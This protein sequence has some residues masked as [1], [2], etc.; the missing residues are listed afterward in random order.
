MQIEIDTALGPTV[1]EVDDGFTSMPTANQTAL[2]DRARSEIEMQ[3]KPAPADTQRWRSALGQ[4]TLM[5]F[6]DEAEAAFWN[7]LDAIGS[8]VGLTDGAEYNAELKDIRGKLDAYR[9]D[10][11]LEALAYEMGGAVL[12]ALG[13]GLLSMGTGGAAVGAATAAR[14]AP[15]VGRLAKVGAVQGGVSGFGAGE[16]GIA[17]RLGSGATGAVIGGALGAAAPTV[18]N[19]G[20]RAVR[21]VGDSL[22]I[23]GAK[24]AQTFSERKMLEALQRDGMTPEEA[25]TRLQ[26][27]QA[28][29]VP[30]IVPADL[31]ENLR[32]AA[33]RSQAVPNPNRQAVVDQFAERQT[34]QAGQIADAA[35]DVAGSPRTGFD[36]IDDLDATVR[37]EAKPAYDLAYQQMLDPKPFQPFMGRKVIVDAYRRAQDLADIR[38]D[39]N[40]PPLDRLLS[41]NAIPTE[42]AHQIKQ[43]L[44][45]LIEA[46]TDALT[47]KVTSR[48]RELVGLKNQWNDAIVAQNDNYR[49]ANAT[50]ADRAR[51]RDGFAMGSKFNAIP[52]KELVRKVGKMTPAEREA[53][54]SG[55]ITKVQELASSTT[56]ATNF[57]KTIFGS[58]Q[59]RMALRLAF[60]DPKEFE[61]FEK[62]IR[63]QTDKVRTT[64]KV[65]G[66][67]STVE[68]QI[69]MQ[70]GGIDPSAL[71]D[72][73]ANA[74]TGNAMGMVRGLAQQGAARLTGMNEKSAESMSRMLFEADPARQQEMLN[75][76]LRRQI[77]DRDARSSV[78]ARPETYSG[79]IG[80][81]SGL[82]AGP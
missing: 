75:A 72:L 27:A 70:D 32:G 15:T 81:M 58:P 65:M 33:W 11:P 44:D 14:L 64:N 57:V 41:G 38:G 24:R 31:G 7:P 46:E 17:N 62:F 74:A 16:G 49:V 36:F 50:F 25:L 6:G 59:R 63:V 47:G 34:S 21:S 55:V 19:L 82:L 69:A 35:T 78:F 53:M 43:G 52:E 71:V 1:I 4:G 61:R 73:G 29:G 2:I 67:S 9:S 5:G 26:E 48:G 23:G 76:L 54:K 28:M 77:M 80:N 13:A 56:D 68:R 45:A 8:A 22:G 37:A 66:N 60:G 79:F 40:M 51:L 3:Y 20:G 18:A 42:A 39:G 30:D 10:R 12:P